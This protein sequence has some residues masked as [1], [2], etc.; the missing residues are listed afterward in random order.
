MCALKMSTTPD[1]PG[2]VGIFWC[3]KE[4]LMARPIPLH[5]AERRGT[6]LD[7]PEAHVRV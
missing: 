5:Q 6:R 7:S 2:R 3:Y 1:T 4:F